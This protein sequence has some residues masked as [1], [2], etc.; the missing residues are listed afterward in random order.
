MGTD[1]ITWGVLEELDVP[2]TNSDLYFLDEQKATGY[3]Q[4]FPAAAQLTD[5]YF[6]GYPAQ[7]GCRYTYRNDT[8]D[9]TEVV[10]VMSHKR[11]PFTLAKCK[12]ECMTTPWCTGI[13]YQGGVRC[14]QSNLV[15]MTE[16]NTC[17]EG[18]KQQGKCPTG[19]GKTIANPCLLFNTPDINS[20]EI[21]L[22]IKKR[23]TIISKIQARCFKKLCTPTP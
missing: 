2:Y 19:K 1:A 5:D 4:L 23:K 17:N 15:S 6:F 13:Q 20:A 11:K 9:Y 14:T 8:A 7:G 12:H 22:K 21:A 3:D 16:T 10:D 18:C